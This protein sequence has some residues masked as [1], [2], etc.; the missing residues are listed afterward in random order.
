MT[1]MAKMH[2]ISRRQS[3]DED[4]EPN[5]LWDA[6][7]NQFD[8]KLSFTTFSRT[9]FKGNETEANDWL[10][11]NKRKFIRTFNAKG[12]V[13]TIT[14]YSDRAKVCFAY[15]KVKKCRKENCCYYHV[16]QE[17][18]FGKCTYGSRCMYGHNLLHNSHNKEL[19][20][21]HGFESLTSDQL[22]ILINFSKLVVCA[23]S[24]PV[25]EQVFCTRLHVCPIWLRNNC[26]E[27]E[28]DCIGNHDF[29]SRLCRNLLKQYKIDYLDDEDIKRFIIVPRS[30]INRVETSFGL[31]IEEQHPT[32]NYGRKIP[33]RD[34]HTAT[35]GTIKNTLN[36][37]CTNTT[38]SQKETNTQLT[39][40]TSGDIH[41]IK[42]TDAVLICEE[43]LRG[44]CSRGWGCQNHHFTEPFL[45]QCFHNSKWVS[46]FHENA[47]IEERYRDPTQ[48]FDFISFR[49]RRGD[50]KPTVIISILISVIF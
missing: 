38:Q 3:I 6:I 21:R 20:K 5:T 46:L 28:E 40:N 13:C 23:A 50:K 27:Q 1:S 34:A 29:G 49:L 44:A 17:N 48:D 15:F 42:S 43:N 25:D 32:E 4:L 16:C 37:H 30:S 7:L 8:G 33:F 24:C 45:W 14:V 31:E 11:N 26:D 41:I 19:V 9:F 47:S 18:V 22:T 39:S 36:H 2:H 10:E 12:R 35:N